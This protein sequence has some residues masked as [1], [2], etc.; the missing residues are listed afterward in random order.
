[1]CVF[2]VPDDNTPATD[3]IIRDILSLLQSYSSDTLI[4]VEKLAFKT[5]ML[6]FKVM[7]LKL[8][9]KIKKNGTFCNAKLVGNNRQR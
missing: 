2:G 1:M 7:L 6:S 5:P 3:L 8:I 9:S 4:S